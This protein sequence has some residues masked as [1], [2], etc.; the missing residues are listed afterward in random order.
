ML[1]YV[2]V[3][4]GV[5]A[6]DRIV[7]YAVVR[8]LALGESVP[9]IDGFFHITRHHNTGAAFSTFLGKQG[10]LI[11][12]TSVLLVACL[13]LLW[14]KGRDLGRL[15]CVALAMVLGGGLGNLWDRIAQGHVVDMFDF[16]VFPIFNVADIFVTA[17]CG[18][19]LIY[20]LFFDG[21]ERREKQ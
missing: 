5:V 13:L 20:F 4:I 6:V 7:K 21:R 1:Y 14:K 15:S 2:L 9:V 8:S 18:L 19:L 12:L 17:G 11:L 3:I 10:F 16:R